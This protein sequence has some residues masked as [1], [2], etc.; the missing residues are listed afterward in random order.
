MPCTKRIRTLRAVDYYLAVMERFRDA[1]RRKRS[2]FKGDII[3]LEE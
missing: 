2:N 1:I 3:V